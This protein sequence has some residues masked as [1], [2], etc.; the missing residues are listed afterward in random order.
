MLQN[1]ILSISWCSVWARVAA[2]DVIIPPSRTLALALA[3]HL[4][5]YYK[6]TC[7]KCHIYIYTLGSWNLKEVKDGK[8]WDQ[9]L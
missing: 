6:D 5:N 9:L 3:L 1:G 8:I 7:A 2:M 4:H